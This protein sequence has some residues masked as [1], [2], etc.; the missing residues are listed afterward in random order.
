MEHLAANLKK[1]GIKDFL[2]FFPP[3]K[4][5]AKVFDAHFRGAGLP[6]V[7]DWFVKRQT[8]AAKEALA[9][10]LKERLNAEETND[11]ARSLIVPGWIE[12]NH[13]ISPD[14]RSGQR[15]AS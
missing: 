12:L 5:N 7:S 3:N 15:A 6:Q 10:E 1:G 2:A 8:A 13:F 9:Q 14:H 11:Q 4:R